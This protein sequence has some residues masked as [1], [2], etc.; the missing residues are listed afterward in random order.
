MAD[1]DDG[2]D[3]TNFEDEF[4]RRNQNI[5]DE[6]MHEI[7]KARGG[8]SCYCPI[9]VKHLA[10]VRPQ[11]STL[12]KVPDALGKSKEIME[13]DRRFG[14]YFQSEEQDF[15][16]LMKHLLSFNEKIKGCELLFPETVFF[17]AGRPT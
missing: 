8:F 17:T 3:E 6:K 7:H 9:C 5:N 12:H 11:Q 1:K 2:D 16:W 14:Q 13:S 10:G 15:C 4:L